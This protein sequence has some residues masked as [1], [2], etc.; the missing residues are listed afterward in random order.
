MW[1]EMGV[2]RG[3]TSGQGTI[4]ACSSLCMDAIPGTVCMMMPV[5]L[6]MNGSYDRG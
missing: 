6:L 2:L 4:E 5:T 1:S 3:Q